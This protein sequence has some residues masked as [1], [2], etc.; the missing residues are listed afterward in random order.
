MREVEALLEMARLGRLYPSVVLHGAEGE[1]RRSLAED[2]ARRLL[3]ERD[4]PDR[5]CGE[6]RHCRRIDRTRE[7]AFHPDLHVLERDLRTVTSAEGTKA[8][9]R[10]AWSA[11]YEAR[12]QVFVIAEAETLSPEAA[13]ALLKILEEPPLASPR[14]FLLLASSRHDLLPTLLSRSLVVYLGGSRRLAEDRL[15]EM[16][17]ELRPL[18]EAWEQGQGAVVLLA[19]ADVLG[20][21]GDWSDPRDTAP[22]ATAAAALVRS[23]DGSSASPP[24]RRRLLAF[25]ADLFDGPRYRVRRIPEARLIEGW[26]ARR[27]TGS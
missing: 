27:L 18:W 7:D 11:P 6:C 17:G 16:A 20:G 2:L 3:C 23:L 5:P 26:L 4:E 10:Q 15:E 8:F 13:D 14:T 22:W 21:A 12:G 1:A 9:L 24:L 25:A 19:A